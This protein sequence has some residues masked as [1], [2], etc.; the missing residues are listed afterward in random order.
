MNKLTVLC[1]LQ[2]YLPRRTKEHIV[3]LHQQSP[4]KFL[5]LAQQHA[6]LMTVLALL[7][8]RSLRRHHL[9]VVVASAHFST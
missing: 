4:Q 5:L 3:Q 8:V 6:V 7:N 2:N 9:G 1:S